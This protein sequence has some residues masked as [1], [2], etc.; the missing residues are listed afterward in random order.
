MTLKRLVSVLALAGVVFSLLA[1]VPNGLVRATPVAFGSS[2]F[3]ACVP[4]GGMLMTNI[5][6]I[7]F[8]PHGATNLGPVTGDL[9]GS[10]AAT[11]IASGVGY[12]HYWVTSSGD[13][14]N[15]ADAVLNAQPSDYLENGTV[16]AVRWGKYISKITGGTGKFAGATGSLEYFGLADFV[17]NTLVLRYQGQ[18]CYAAP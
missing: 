8:G 11:P 4:V 10:V 17:N 3:P 1:F 5:G 18:V 2:P 6:V 7:P 14:I 13:T 9:A 16:V 12:H 15:F